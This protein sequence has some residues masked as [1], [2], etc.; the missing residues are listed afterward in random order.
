MHLARVPADG[1]R[2]ACE[3]LLTMGHAERA[4][5]PYLHPGRVDVIAGGAFVGKRCS[6]GRWSARP[7]AV[8]VPS[9]HDIL[10]GIA[11][12]LSSTPLAPGGLARQTS[13]RHTDGV[14]VAAVIRIA[15]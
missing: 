11:L 3:S 10:D 4:A 5:L 1:H 15:R 13:P 7:A 2:A 14:P 12:S 8:V 9:E 6:T